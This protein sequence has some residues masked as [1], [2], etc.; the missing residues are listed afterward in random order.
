MKIVENK[1]NKY[2]NF[3][4]L[5]IGE[6]FKCDDKYYLKTDL[7]LSPG[8]PYMHAVSISD[9]DCILFYNYDQIIPVK[10]TLTIDED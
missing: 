9:G 4:D 8:E 10:A 1:K 2:I 6:V 3:E 7:R 5:E